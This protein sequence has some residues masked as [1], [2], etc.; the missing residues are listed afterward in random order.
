MVK[1]GLLI[2]GSAARAMTTER[3][4]REKRGE[5][6]NRQRERERRKERKEMSSQGKEKDIFLFY[7]C[8]MHMFSLCIF[9]MHRISVKLMIVCSKLVLCTVFADDIWIVNLTRKTLFGFFEKIF[10]PVEVLRVK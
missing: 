6:E 8:H 4:R 1:K 10:A 7:K 9:N 2:G 3:R 5:S